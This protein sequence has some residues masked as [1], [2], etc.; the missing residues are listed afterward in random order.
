MLADYPI[1]HLIPGR[2]EY[3]FRE[4]IFKL[5]LVIDGSG[6]SNKIAIRWMPQELSDDK[7][8]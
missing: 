3:N 2:F 6:I 7:S 8:T 1:N 5:I 4:A